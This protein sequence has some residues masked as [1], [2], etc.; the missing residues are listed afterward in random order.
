MLILGSNW[1][2]K[3]KGN[4]FL[5]SCWLWYKLYMKE[6]ILSVMNVFYFDD[7]FYIHNPIGLVICCYMLLF[8]AFFQVKDYVGK[9]YA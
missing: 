5:G 3:E 8:V 7:W 1:R 2:E 9:E 6:I 4:M